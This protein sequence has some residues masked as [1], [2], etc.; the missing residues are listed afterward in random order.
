M[1]N[2]IVETPL[3]KQYF[4]IKAKH[5]DEKTLIGDCVE[6]NV[7]QQMEQA[8]AQSTVLSEMVKEGVLHI[9]GGVY[10]LTTGTVEF[11]ASSEH[12]VTKQ[13]ETKFHQESA[14]HAGKDKE[15]THGH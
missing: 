14:S 15:K 10:S 9:A 11:L 13:E 8:A 3:M 7:R 1:I 6:E 12:T 5:P 4:E 2:D